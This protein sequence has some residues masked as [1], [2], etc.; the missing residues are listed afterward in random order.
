MQRLNHYLLFAV[1]WAMT[2][3]PNLGA[4]SL[5]DIDEGNNAAC[6]Y[7]MLESGNWIVP[8]FNYH[9]RDDKPALI[10]WLQM[11]CYHTFG[12][13]ET[14]ARLP[15]AL[16]ALFTIV[17]VYELGRRMFGVGTGLLAGL[18][19]GGSIG[20]LGAAH[21][22]N[23]DAL[24]V[25]FCTLTLALVWTDQQGERRGTLA[26]VG[27]ACGLA[28]LAKGPIGALAPAGICVAYL[29]WQRQLS[30]L[31]D[32][33]LGDVALACFL[34]AAP[35]YVWVTVDTRGAWIKGFWNKHHA[36]RVTTA[37]ENHSGP[38][39]YYL[40]V[41]CVGLLPWSIFLGPTVYHTWRRLRQPDA[42]DRPAVRF[43][44]V[45]AGAF[46]VFFS[47]VR[48]KLPNYILPVYPALALL[49]AHTLQR[50]RIGEWDVPKWML[51]M[52]LACMALT[53]VGLAAG[54][55][56]GAGVLEVRAHPS[57]LYPDLAPWAWL[58][59]LFVGAAA[60]GW[61]MLERDRRAGVLVTVASAGVLFAALIAGGGILAIEPYKATKSLAAA[62]PENHLEREV[63][64]ATYCFFQPSLVF[65]CRREI[66][67]LDAPAQATEFL[68]GPHESYLF[69]PEGVWNDELRATAPDGVRVIEARHDLYSNRRV[70]LVGRPAAKG[71]AVAG[72]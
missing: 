2:C 44:V 11:G 54:M 47:L 32:W 56:V 45:W 7:E 65:Y 43:L 72:R 39:Y 28:V 14:A 22:A 24:L 9:L 8:T 36:D 42:T 48:T 53:G 71:E 35:W 50:W 34:V 1:L 46:L 51:R 55:L 27:V 66:R 21:F 5:W 40:L 61:W 16:A 63:R 17:V 57:H 6:G 31:L 20:L 26:W 52:S 33:R 38:L 62:I 37:M 3:L 67:R 12:V 64:I 23:P 10:Y 13:N 29:A 15:S 41:L 59:A 18:I 4:P 30:R 69:V 68:R 19:L 60:L 70:L 58:G 49:T 25:A